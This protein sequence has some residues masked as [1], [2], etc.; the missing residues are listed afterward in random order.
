MKR[1]DQIRSALVANE[2]NRPNREEPM[3]KSC[4][5]KKIRETLRSNGLHVILV[6]AAWD[7]AGAIIANQIVPN[8]APDYRGKVGFCKVDSEHK[9]NK[10]ITRFFGINHL[11]TTLFVQGGEIKDRVVGPLPARSLRAKLDQLLDGGI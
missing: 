1:L 5:G 3:M 2:E 9:D 6:T 4:D 10:E 11:P 8:V 7:G